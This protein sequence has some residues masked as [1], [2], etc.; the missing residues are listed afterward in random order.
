MV[1][2]DMIAIDIEIIT[3]PSYVFYKT[4]YIVMGTLIGIGILSGPL[5]LMIYCILEK[6][7]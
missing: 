7:A 5:Y 2:S 4:R 3:E 6:R 1:P